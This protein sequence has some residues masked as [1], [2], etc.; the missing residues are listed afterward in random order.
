MNIGVVKKELVC[1]VKDKS[2]DAAKIF[3]VH[4]LDLS[5]KETG[6]YVVAVDKKLGIGSGDIVL[7][8]G[9]SSARKIVGYDN[10][11]INAGISAKVESLHIDPKYK[12]LMEK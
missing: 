5:G 11:P 9:G 1:S 6:K 4:I 3:L 8:V 2:M 7:I 10:M 12:F